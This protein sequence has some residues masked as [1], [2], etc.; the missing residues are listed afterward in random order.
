MEPVGNQFNFDDKQLE[1]I[2][3]PVTAAGKA[4]AG[5]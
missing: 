5:N 2:G 4:A 1:W 3:K